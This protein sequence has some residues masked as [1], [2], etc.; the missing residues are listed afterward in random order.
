M[1]WS[2][3]DFVKFPHLKKKKGLS[4]LWFGFILTETEYQ[5][6]NPEK[7]LHTNVKTRFTF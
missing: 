6:K 1:I 3:A 7:K 5:T 4:F 2:P